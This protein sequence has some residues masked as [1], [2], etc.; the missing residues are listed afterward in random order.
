MSAME[1]NLLTIDDVMR[2]GWIA[3]AAI[4][5][6]VTV[7]APFIAEW[8]KVRNR[9]KT[10]DS[11]VDLLRPA[12]VLWGGWRRRRAMSKEDTANGSTA[13][14]VGVD[15]LDDISPM[16]SPTDGQM[17]VAPPS[18]NEGQDTKSD[19][20]AEVESPF[21]RALSTKIEISRSEFIGTYS[22][23]VTVSNVEGA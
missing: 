5:P 14:A 4:A 1:R 21:A 22:E 10:D 3:I 8:I 12:A 7:V 9:M 2:D 20:V 16:I 15:L 19:V 11:V 17:T 18:C 13:S 23:D 6:A